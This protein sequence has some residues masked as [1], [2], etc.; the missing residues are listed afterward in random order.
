MIQ[1]VD[2]ER[3][4]QMVFE[5]ER[6]LART[7]LIPMTAIFERHA[8]GSLGVRLSA[9]RAR[10]T[11]AGMQDRRVEKRSAFHRMVAQHRT[12]EDQSVECASLFHPTSE[13]LA[14]TNH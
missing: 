13:H 1:V 2:V 12:P 10:P 8:G 7:E 3:I 4:E 14:V 9:E 11:Q 6:K 5:G